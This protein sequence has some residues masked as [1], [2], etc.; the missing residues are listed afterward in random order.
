MASNT[1]H[2]IKS[3]TPKALDVFF[4]DA[5][6]WIYIFFPRQNF[7]RQYQ[8]AY[9]DFFSKIRSR[10]LPIYINALILSELSNAYMNDAYMVWKS[11]QSDQSKI[12]KKNDFRPSAEYKKALLEIKTIIETIL[13]I[14][15]R[16]SDEFNSISMVDVLNE[17]ASKEFNDSYYV[18]F[19]KH[20]KIKI[21]THDSD[22]L[23]NNYLGIE[24]ITANT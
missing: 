8:I 10:N 9:S 2:E 4:F 24:V 7:Q 14:A 19:A 20:K 17:H 3:Y 16:S 15:I 1:I 6:V 18:V 5:N 12:N 23:K 22:I 13:K 11:N 21:V